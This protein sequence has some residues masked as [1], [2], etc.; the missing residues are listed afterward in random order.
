MR[1]GLYLLV[2]MLVVRVAAADDTSSHRIYA[3]PVVRP[4][5]V[6]PASQLRRGNQGW[7]E[8]NYV[9][10]KEGEVIEPVVEAS[11]GSRAF[12]R[13]AINAV[14]RFGYE[15]ALLDGEPI[16]Q[17]KTA[18]R[19][20]FAIDGSERGVSKRFRSQYRKMSAAVDRG[21]ID[22]ASKELELAFETDG[23]T[24]GEVSWLWTLN[25]RIAGIQGD[26]KQQLIAVRRALAG[27]EKWIPV[28]LR[29][30]LL[31]N[32]FVLEI[33][34]GNYPA[35]MRA[36]TLLKRVYDVNTSKFDPIAESIR[37]LAESEKLL[38]KA[39]EIGGDGSCDSCVSQW[40]YQPLRRAIEITEIDGKL[41]NL[42]LRCEWQR[43]VDEAREGV[44]W[45]I[46]DSWGKCNVIV[47]G[48]A[49][50]TFKL[51]ELPVT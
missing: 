31:K 21:E 34:Q 22:S 3:K 7:V 38:V 26:K 19:I 41:E 28:K 6:Y 11:S 9:V 44:A 30:E 12:E 18:V 48:E 35:A 15:P 14:K 32:R 10:T 37:T 8:L 1:I 23:L 25:A 20:T 24:L 39:A 45:E 50:S 13:A 27:S 51:V 42:E 5:P 36:Y 2:V 49:G 4:A 29:I 17:C 40:Q 46:P 47:H 16:Q 43:Y 33:L